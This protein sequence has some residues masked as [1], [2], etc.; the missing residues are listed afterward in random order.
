MQ[1][2]ITFLMFNNQTEE[3]VNLYVSVFK[4]AKI[5]SMNRNGGL[6]MSATFQL[7]GQEF[8]AFNGGSYFT[9]SNG[10]SLFVNCETQEE[11][12]DLWD[13]LSEDGEKQQCGWL[14]DKFGI[15]W[16]IIPTALTKL[17]QDKD[18]QKSQRVMQAMLK[19]KKII[20]ADLQKAYAG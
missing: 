11:V 13:K 5:T 12:D 2:I 19:M 8:H 4:D 10:I 7:A 3:A 6:V 1:K 20:I 17:M 14:K 18:P 9:F 16:Q 15:H